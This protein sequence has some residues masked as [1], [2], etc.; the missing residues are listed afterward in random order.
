MNNPIQPSKFN[1]LPLHIAAKSNDVNQITSLLDNNLVQEHINDKTDHG[2][3]A[4]Y[5]SAQHN[6]LEILQLLHQAGADINISD[7]GGLTP[8]HIASRNGHLNIV[9][10][11]LSIGANP[12]QVDSIQWSALHWALKNDHDDLIALLSQHTA[13][14]IKQHALQVREKQR[15]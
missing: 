15:R 8:L 9:Q 11:L 13:A 12:N 10:A 5:I 6:N 2:F 3:T 14:E 7:K 1:R 4:I